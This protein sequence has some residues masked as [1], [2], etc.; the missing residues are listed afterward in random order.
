MQIVDLYEDGGCGPEGAGN[1]AAAFTMELMAE[2]G[3][4]GLS[5]V[6]SRVAGTC[7]DYPLL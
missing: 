4:E 3:P 5:Y 1:Y 7:S 2:F 6:L